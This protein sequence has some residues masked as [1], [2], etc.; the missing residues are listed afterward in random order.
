MLKK[1]FNENFRKLPSNLKKIKFGANFNKTLENLPDKVE[2]IDFGEDFSQSLASLPESVREIK[3]FK[4]DRLSCIFP[5]NVK[6]VS[7]IILFR[8]MIEYLPSHIEELHLYYYSEIDQILRNITE[9]FDNDDGKWYEYLTKERFPNLNK[10]VIHDEKDYYVDLLAR[11]FGKD[12]VTVVNSYVKIM[13]NKLL[14]LPRIMS[15]GYSYIK[16][17][18][19]WGINKVFGY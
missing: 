12:N 10:L 3:F 1:N 13:K 18:I 4:I 16:E 9:S 2:Y 8:N 19:V 6:K 11:R 14:V 17:D 5:T 15:S 7:F